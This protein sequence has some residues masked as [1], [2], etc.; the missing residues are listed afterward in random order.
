A[1]S[2]GSSSG[3][4]TD[5]KGPD[6]A[7]EMIRFFYEHP[8]REAAEPT[9]AERAVGPAGHAAPPEPDKL[10]HNLARSA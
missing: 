10:G 6:A 9:Y 1:W 5:P 7:K 2:G 4:Y 8:R 3:S